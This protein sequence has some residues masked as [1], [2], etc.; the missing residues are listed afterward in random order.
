V[1]E[2][3]QKNLPLLKDKIVQ[4]ATVAVVNGIC[5]LRPIRAD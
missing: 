3:L 1:P 5:D 2:D 4:K